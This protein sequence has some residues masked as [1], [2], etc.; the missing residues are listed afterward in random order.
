MDRGDLRANNLAGPFKLD[1]RSKAVHLENVTGD[2]RV[3]DTNASVEVTT[4]TPLGNIEISNARG[5]IEVALPANAGFQIDAESRSGDIQSD[6]PLD[7]D[8]R[9][10]DAAA[11]G[12]VGKGGPVVRL[13]AER[14]TIQIRKE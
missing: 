9:R 7:G 6:F 3:D 4:R 5:G 10:R 2:V 13:R 12:T 14:G 1:T 11:R 8:N